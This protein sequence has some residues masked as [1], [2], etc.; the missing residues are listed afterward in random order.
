[1]VA[2]DPVPANKK[3]A[4]GCAMHGKVAHLGVHADIQSRIQSSYSRSR[5]S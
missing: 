1:M 2:G 4:I 5:A 3:I